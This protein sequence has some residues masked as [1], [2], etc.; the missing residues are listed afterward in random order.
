MIYRK[1]FYDTLK[2]PEINLFIYFTGK[3]ATG[4]EGILNEWDSRK[5]KDHRWLAYMLAT[6]Y[7]E[8]GKMMQPIEE[9]GKGKKLKYGMPDKETNKVY[10]GRGF[11]QLTWKDNYF[12]FEKELGVPLVKQP[13][14]ALDVEISTKILFDGMIKGMFTGKKLS[15]Y[16][17]GEDT[18]DWY[19]AR[20]IING[21]DKAGEIGVYAQKFL[22]AINNI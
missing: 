21:R 9:W 17:N 2:A 4:L 8:T 11:V 20:A 1:L 6:V 3:Q 13:E 16:F 10:Y 14:L 12:K 15:D 7:H 18:C 22:R 19:G 5:Q